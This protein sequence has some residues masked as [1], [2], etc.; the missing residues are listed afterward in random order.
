MLIGDSSITE[1]SL[2]KVTTLAVEL[3]KSLKINLLWKSILPAD[4][5]STRNTL[6][7]K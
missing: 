4:Q 1:L 3:L 6:N 5:N 7:V 2:S